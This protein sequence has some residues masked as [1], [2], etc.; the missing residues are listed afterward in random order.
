[1]GCALRSLRETDTSGR[2]DPFSG[3]ARGYLRKLP[4]G[5]DL[6]RS[7]ASVLAGSAQFGVVIL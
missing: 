1:M 6:Q 3:E 7:G 4:M 2:S 5:G